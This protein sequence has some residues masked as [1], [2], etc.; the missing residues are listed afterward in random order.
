[1]RNPF[2]KRTDQLSE[3]PVCTDLP[4]LVRHGD[5]LVQQVPAI[6][7]KA[8][9]R[10][11]QVLVRGEATGHSH[12]V[13]EA[14]AGVVYETADEMFLEITSALGTLVHEEHGP[15]ELPRGYYRVWTQREY[16]PERIVRVVD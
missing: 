2:R 4:F 11:G 16:T 10:N 3:K 9:R 13:G 1:M 8:R 12:R 14:G 5:V 7:S 6:P 15:I